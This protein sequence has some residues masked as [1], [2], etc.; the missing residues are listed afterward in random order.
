[1]Q[2]RR[3]VQI[4]GVVA[5][6]AGLIFWAYWTWPGDTGT[7]LVMPGDTM[8]PNYSLTAPPKPLIPSTTA[9][10]PTAASAEPTTLPGQIAGMIALSTTA[11][12]PQVM[13]T[14]VGTPRTAALTPSSAAAPPPAPAPPAVPTLD[15]VPTP[16]PTPSPVPAPTTPSP[17]PAPV[18]SPS[19]SLPS[20][21]SS[22]AAS[23]QPA[24]PK[25]P[26]A[27]P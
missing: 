23:I 25:V 5:S 21:P 27:T 8:R 15:P 26:P 17:S 18:P 16:R 9:P 6:V 12:A 20:S 19:I 7:T 22:P 13:P 10:S 14:S 24:S 4:T 1:M 11:L 3:L 2:R